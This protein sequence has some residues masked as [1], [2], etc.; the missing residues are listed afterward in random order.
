MEDGFLGPCEEI[1]DGEPVPSPKDLRLDTLQIINP[2]TSPINIL[3][4]LRPQLRPL[5]YNPTR[6]AARFSR[7]LFLIL[8]LVPPFE[9]LEIKQTD[10][11]LKIA[12]LFPDL[13]KGAVLLLCSSVVLADL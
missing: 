10:R 13:P 9:F 3:F 4:L 1:E 11:Y 5:L 2:P 12:V 7:N 6:R 8:V